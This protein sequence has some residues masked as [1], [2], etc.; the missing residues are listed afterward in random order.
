MKLKYFGWDWK[1]IK[2]NYSTTITTKFKSGNW[3]KNV[4]H[5]RVSAWTTGTKSTNSPRFAKLFTMKMTLSKEDF[6]KMTIPSSRNSNQ[7]GKKIWNSWM[8]FKNGR[9]VIRLLKEVNQRNWMISGIWWSLKG[10]AWSIG[11]SDKS[12]S[13][14]KTN[15]LSWRIRS[16][17]GE[18]CLTIET[19][20]LKI[21]G[22]R[23]KGMKFPSWSWKTMR[24][25]SISLKIKLPSWINSCWD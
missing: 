9:I 4:S 5:S 8:K 20:K 19:E 22:R 25:W 24:Q 21:W 16:A 10:R 6:S 23:F 15:A 12:P 17:K 7:R 2:D 11:K 13:G 1:R 14:F 18:K 3:Q